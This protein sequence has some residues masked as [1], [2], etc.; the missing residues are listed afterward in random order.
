MMISVLFIFGGFLALGL[1]ILIA[2]YDLRSKS[3]PLYLLILFGLASLFELSIQSTFT[4]L[5]PWEHF[6]TV[7]FIVLFITIIWG[8]EGYAKR[9]LLGL[10]D[11]ILLPCCGLWLPFDHIP[12]YFIISGI[13][14]CLMGVYWK[15]NHQER[16][17]PFAP[18]LLLGLF[19]CIYCS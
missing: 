7:L 3:I 15:K 14:G 12:Y 10:G 11:K 18:I 4:P 5:F 19:I 6:Y 17:F 9:P 1:G 8:I 16:R 13:I 2:Y